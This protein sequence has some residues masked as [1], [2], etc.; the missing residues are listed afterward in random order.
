MAAVTP[1][2]RVI[3]DNIVAVGPDG[4]QRQLLPVALTAN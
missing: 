4:T 3:F 2:T 1:G